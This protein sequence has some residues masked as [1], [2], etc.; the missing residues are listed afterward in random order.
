MVFATTMLSLRSGTEP[1]SAG[2]RLNQ[3][4][5]GIAGTPSGQGYWLFARDGGVLTFGDARFHGSLG[6]IRLNQP[7]VGGVPTERGGGYWLGAADG[8]VFAFGSARF[9]GSLGAIHL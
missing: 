4:V 8:G 2:L 6:A 3:P 7:I 1:P 9:H 5:V